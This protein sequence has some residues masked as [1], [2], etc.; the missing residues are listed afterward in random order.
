M[1]EFRHDRHVQEWWVLFQMEIIIVLQKNLDIVIEDP[2]L[3]FVT[4]DIRELIA[5]LAKIHI[6]KL[7]LIAFLKNYAPTIVMV[8][9]FAI[10]I[11]VLAL[12][13][14]IV[15]ASLAKFY[16]AVLTVLYVSV[17]PTRNVCNAVLVII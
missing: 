5:L 16:C 8:R 9:A 7:A 4:R 12:V 17:A 10:L 15:L 14:R 6:S 3:V 13:F 1:K 2:V 11:T